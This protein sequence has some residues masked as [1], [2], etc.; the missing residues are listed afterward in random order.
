MNNDT[1]IDQAR[2]LYAALQVKQYTQSLK[3]K[4]QF[5]RLDRLVI[6]AYQRYRRRLNRCILCYQH[7]LSDCNRKFFG[8][9]QQLCPRINHSHNGKKTSN[10]DR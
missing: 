4:T 8:T 3:S 2:H 10:I 7:R 6:W 1:L 5:D 9:E